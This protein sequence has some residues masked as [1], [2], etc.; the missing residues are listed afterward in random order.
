[1]KISIG[2]PFYN[3]E[4]FLT[5]AIGSVLKQSF[6]D[7]ELI[8][9]DDGSTDGSLAIAR[10]FKDP[11]IRLYSDGQNMGI[12]YRLNEQI[13]LARGQYFARMDADDIM[14]RERIEIQLRYLEN[15]PTID[16]IGSSAVVIDDNNCIIG[17]RTPSKYKR[18]EQVF[19][20]VYFI[21][22]TVTGKTSWF[23]TYGYLQELKGVEDFDL[24]IRSFNHSSFLNIERPLLFYRDPPELKIHTYKFR[25]K[26]VRRA[27][28]TNRKLLNKKPYL[29]IFLF[30]RTYIKTLIMILVKQVKYDKYLI[31]RRNILPE[32]DSK[33]IYQQRLNEMLINH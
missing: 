20:K 9:I 8:L 24:W 22:P 14:D 15:N 33:D 17:L 29:M 6:T 10:S 31:A 11:R 1:M 30:I 13:K 5:L 19:R 7:F 12:A 4:K 26:Q 16:V 23:R 18:L 32:R 21:H 3:A 28:W 27:L 2:I 25:Q